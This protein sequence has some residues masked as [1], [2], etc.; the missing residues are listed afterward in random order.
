MN[1]C[2]SSG[3]RPEGTS[4]DRS[5]SGT[6]A[7]MLER[8]ASDHF[9][10]MAK[11]ARALNTSRAVIWRWRKEA[12]YKGVVPGDWALRIYHL[13]G[14]KVPLRIDDYLE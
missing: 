1:V 14:K 2:L 10:N 8:E 3:P 5:F 13:S 4:L 7:D 12:R 11:L 9:G 6:I